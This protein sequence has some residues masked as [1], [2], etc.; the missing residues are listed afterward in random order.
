MNRRVLLLSISLL[1]VMIAS[2]MIY[3]VL[4]IYLNQELGAGKVQVG[5]LFTLGALTGTLTS[6][7]IGRL[8]DRIGKVPLILFSQ[9]CFS[10]VM[11]MYSFINSYIFA[12]PIHIFEGFAWASLG[13]SAPA[14]IADLSRKG[15]RG[16]AMGIYNTFWGLGW[17]IGPI[18]GGGLAELFGFRFMLRVSFLMIMLGLA[19]SLILIKGSIMQ[20]SEMSEL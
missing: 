20:A 14:L 8:A 17:V 15:E 4:P 7:G 1:P 11:V 3:S 19:L 5:T 6:L 12:Y 2:G 13:V 10:A 16:E 9:I 18:L